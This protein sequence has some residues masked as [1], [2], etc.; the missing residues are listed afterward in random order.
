MSLTVM[1]K[2]KANIWTFEAKAIKYVVQ[3]D[4]IAV[5]NHSHYQCDLSDVA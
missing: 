2:I 1:L 3:A 5:N 4:Y